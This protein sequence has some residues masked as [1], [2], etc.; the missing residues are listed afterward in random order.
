M[1]YGISGAGM[2]LKKLCFL[3]IS[4][5]MKHPDAFL[6]IDIFNEKVTL[7]YENEEYLFTS[8]KSFRKSVTISGNSYIGY[9]STLR[10]YL[11]SL[12]GPTFH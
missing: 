6:V 5:F 7:K 12:P 3:P 4:L 8:S 11:L 1:R 10:L 2:V 9:G